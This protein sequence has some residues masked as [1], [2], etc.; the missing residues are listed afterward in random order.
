MVIFS[1]ETTKIAKSMEVATTSGLMAKFTKVN[2]TMTV[3]K[4]RVN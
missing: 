3:R 2:G 4:V 1:K